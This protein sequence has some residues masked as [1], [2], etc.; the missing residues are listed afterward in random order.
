MYDLSFGMYFLYTLCTRECCN[1]LG[2]TLIWRDSKVN[3]MFRNTFPIHDNWIIPLRLGDQVKGVPP[4]LWY[5]LLV[6]VVYKRMR[7]SSCSNPIC[8]YSRVNHMFR[9]SFPMRDNWIIPLSL[10]DQEKSV[11]PQLWYV[12]LVNMVY[13]R[14]QQSAWSYSKLQIFY[15]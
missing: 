11:P 3:Q 7:N 5:V 15:G 6:H 10:E 9:N 1:R 13:K 14:M 4:Q 2:R 12:L 8:R